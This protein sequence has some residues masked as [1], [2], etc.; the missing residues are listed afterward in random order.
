[1]YKIQVSKLT[2]E[3]SKEVMDKFSNVNSQRSNSGYYLDSKSTEGIKSIE[4]EAYDKF[5]RIMEGV[6][7]KK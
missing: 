1:M 5:K 4:Q 6:A 7:Y 2:E 3:I